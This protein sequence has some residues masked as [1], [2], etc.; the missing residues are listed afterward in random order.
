MIMAK[1]R[2]DL[3]KIREHF[4]QTSGGSGEDKWWNIKPGERG[5]NSKAIIR[6]LPP[7]GK[8]AEGFFYYTAA[9]HYGFSIGGR[10][11]ALGCPESVGKGKCPVCLFISRLRDGTNND[12]LILRIRQSRRYWVNMIDRAEPN[13]I[14]I[15][16]SNKKFVE[17]ILD[18]SEDPDIGDITDP[19]TGRDIIIIRKG[20]GFQ[21][22]YSYRIRATA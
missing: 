16:G 21:T 9:L 6:V 7:W 2:A 1:H 18:A 14:R 5:K 19:K 17:A 20:S 22:R 3:D 13:E 4:Q 15:F 8:S 12:K 10:N 11:R